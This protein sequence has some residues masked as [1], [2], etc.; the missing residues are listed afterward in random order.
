[1]PGV[2]LAL[3]L[4]VAFDNTFVDADRADEVASGPNTAG[5]P[6][7]LFEKRKLG[8]H[9]LCGV[10]FDGGDDFADTPTRGDRG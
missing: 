10:G 7:D 2:S 8:F 4:Y 5:A 3:V 6:V 9:L 1:M